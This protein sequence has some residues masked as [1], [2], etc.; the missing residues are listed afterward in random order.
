MVTQRTDI[1]QCTEASGPH[2]VQ[3]RDG[4]ET[5]ICLLPVVTGKS[6]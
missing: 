3:D 5:D 6:L 4:G 2:G 1:R